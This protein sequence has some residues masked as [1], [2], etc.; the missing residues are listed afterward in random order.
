MYGNA[1]DLQRMVQKY[2]GEQF[3][4]HESDRPGTPLQFGIGDE[5]LEPGEH[6]VTSLEEL[7][8][9]ESFDELGDK[10][11]AALELQP[12][13]NTIVLSGWRRPWW[14]RLWLTLLPGKHCRNCEARL[15]RTDPDGHPS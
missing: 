2:P 7:V 5:P 3:W 9:V 13:S 4:V 6:Y 11:A 14:R 12:V 1:R 8:G 15:H 10:L